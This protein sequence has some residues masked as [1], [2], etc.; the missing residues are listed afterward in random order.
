MP[1]KPSKFRLEETIRLAGQTFRVAGI[2]QLE[3]P[4]AS[5]ATRY[6]LAG[7]DGLA[8][9]LEERGESCSVLRQFSPTAAPHPDG[10]ELSVM[11]MRY[12]LGRVDKLVVLGADGAPV[13]AA[14]PEGLLLSGRFEGEAALILRELAP[15]GAAEQTF[16]TVKP[17]G[18][19]ELV[20]EAQYTAAERER[21]ERLGREATAHAETGKVA[22]ALGMQVGLGVVE[23]LVATMLA[24]ACAAEQ[25]QVSGATPV[26][27][28]E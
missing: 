23:V 17:L 22:G 18:A 3:L 27:A 10:R 25:R 28:R 16:Y 15:G 5:L 4:D 19:G 14:P 12:V 2:A 20:N 1:L 13:G 9:I 26:A 7:D 8:Q 6:L 24:F 21:M 11:G